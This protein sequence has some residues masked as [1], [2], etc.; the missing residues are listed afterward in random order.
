MQKKTE[1]HK[2][3]WLKHSVLA[4]L[5]AVDLMKHAVKLCLLLYNHQTPI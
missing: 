3:I 5:M 2:I 1:H 4:D